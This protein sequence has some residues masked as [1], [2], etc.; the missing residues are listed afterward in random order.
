[1]RL[2]RV[3]IDLNSVNAIRIVEMKTNRREDALPSNYED[4]PWLWAKPNSQEDVTARSSEYILESMRMEGSEGVIAKETRDGLS[5]ERFPLSEESIDEMA[6]KADVLIGKWLVF[7][8][9]SEV[10][11]IWKEIVAETKKGSLGTEAKVSTLFQRKKQHVICI[12]TNDYLNSEDVFRVRKALRRLGLTDVLYYKPDIY[13]YLGIY[14]GTC[15]I[16]P[17]KYK[18]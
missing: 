13:T 2:P 8:D 17:W 18:D 6:R 5:E 7:R 12:Y 10:D 11:G 9:R 16:R 15:S 1:M 14:S 3:A 4:E